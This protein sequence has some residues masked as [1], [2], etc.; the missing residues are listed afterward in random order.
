MAFEKLAEEARKLRALFNDRFT[1]LPRV[2]YQGHWS[3][4]T[5]CPTF[6]VTDRKV[7]VPVATMTPDGRRVVIIPIHELDSLVIYDKWAGRGD[8]TPIEFAYP[9]GFDMVDAPYEF[10]RRS[11]EG[12]RQEWNHSLRNAGNIAHS[13]II[14]PVFLQALT[15][16]GQ[17]G[18]KLVVFP[19]V[20]A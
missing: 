17:G 7:D 4:T 15:E 9:A 5:G 18:G 12:V 19:Q 20:A 6:A 1:H 10:L 14:M 16:A 2:Q 3:D 11:L 13:D 8:A